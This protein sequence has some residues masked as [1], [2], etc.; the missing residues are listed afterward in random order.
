MPP[1]AKTFL[2][3]CLTLM[4][5]FLTSQGASAQYWQISVTGAP[6]T[7]GSSSGNSVTPWNPPAFN[8][9]N[10]LTI[11]PY[12][13]STTISAAPHQTVS[14]TVQFTL[15]FA[16]SFGYSPTPAGEAPPPVIRVK[17]TSSTSWG[18]NTYLGADGVY[19]D[20]GSTAADGLGDAPVNH[21]SSGSTSVYQVNYP[22]SISRTLSAK[23]SGT[24]AAGSGNSGAMLQAK[25]NYYTLATVAVPGIVKV[26]QDQQ[27]FPPA[28]TTRFSATISNASGCVIDWIKISVDGG[29]P[30]AATISGTNPNQ[31]YLDWN[32]SGALN[33]SEHTIF[34]TAQIHDAIGIVPLDSRRPECDGRA[35]DDIIADLRLKSLT[36]N[37][38]IP[39][40]Y[41]A[42]ANPAPIP[43]SA[44]VPTPQ[45]VLDQNRNI[46]APLPAMAYIKGTSI[47]FTIE[48]YPVTGTATIG[49]TLNFTE[50]PVA[51]NE[52]GLT[53][54]QTGT[55]PKVF[56]NPLNLTSQ[57]ALYNEINLYATVI[58]DL[59]FWVQF[60]KSTQNW[61]P[62]QVYASAGQKITNNLYSLLNTPTAP[63]SSPWIG[64]LNY[65]CQYGA[66]ASDPIVATTALTKGLYDHGHYNGGYNLYTDGG[67]NSSGGLIGI[68]D[69]YE[70]FHIQNFMDAN[71]NGQCD[72]FA[73]FLVC[74]SNAVGALP[75][76]A[77]RSVNVAEMNAGSSF[78][79]KNITWSP[80]Q[81]TT[82]IGTPVSWSY[83]QWTTSNIYDGCLRL[84]GTI[85]PLNMAL[86]G[87]FNALVATTVHSPQSQDWDPQPAFLPDPQN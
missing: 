67:K 29:A 48:L 20:T 3:L 79:T 85:S 18:A 34:A 50:K 60:T 32:S 70:A 74:M 23:C 26:D 84:N 10:P 39:L 4:A 56:T 47:P 19:T 83:H 55:V 71:L 5:F 7:T 14:A 54:Y 44:I 58:N 42:S 27:V 16:L 81:S 80:I 52:A 15:A 11:P 73:D 9:T 31:G 37:N 24:V 40:R 25:L 53:L 45:L 35:A 62:V 6:D 76:Q 68:K 61:A 21:V 75:L 8:N 77:Q 86:S 33:P 87:Y 78:T 57:T 13:I 28:A 30:Q 64:V 46:T 49:Y 22:N 38:S 66:G 65:A 69:G 17:E 2:M 36:F 82:A 12:T 63:M 41:S 59:R 43:D 72:D 51:T 1:V